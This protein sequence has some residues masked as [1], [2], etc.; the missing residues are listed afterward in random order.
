MQLEAIPNKTTKKKLKLKL[1]FKLILIGFRA[2]A[3]ILALF[4]RVI[5]RNK[6]KL[7]GTEVN[8][9]NF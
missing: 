6:L 3:L 8:F 2:T 9:C 1:I 5:T 4:G 7:N